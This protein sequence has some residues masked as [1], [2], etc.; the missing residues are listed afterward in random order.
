MS[1]I[2]KALDMSF[3]IFLV[4]VAPA[5]AGLGLIRFA[6]GDVLGKGASLGLF[7]V[8]LFVFGMACMGLSRLS[9][10]FRGKKA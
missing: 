2:T 5:I 3:S 7:L 8:A 1:Y 6:E 4:L 9:E 10:F